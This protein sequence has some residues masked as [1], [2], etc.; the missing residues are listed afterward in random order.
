MN[1]L[2]HRSFEKELKAISKKYHQASK[3][4]DD[5]MRMISEHFNPENSIPII[6]P[7]KLH[8]IADIR[9]SSVWKL[10]LAIP[11]SGLRPSQWPRIWF[12]IESDT[13]AF[14]LLAVHTDNY[15]NNVKDREAISR[16]EEM[17]QSDDSFS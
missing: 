6:D 11:N 5:A 10:E 8:H 17:R 1:E 4:V 15:D 3:A 9:N 13:C 12:A 7:G 2:R 14:L 16:F